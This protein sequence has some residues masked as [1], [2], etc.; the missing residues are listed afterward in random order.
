MRIMHVMDRTGDTRT[1]WDP[2]RPAEVEA[3]RKQCDDDR[4]GFERS[5][6]VLQRRLRPKVTVF[7]SAE[8]G[9]DRGGFDRRSVE[10]TRPERESLHAHSIGS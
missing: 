4:H 1:I 3:A 2:N 10:L 5:G 8:R 6:T 9:A 7:P